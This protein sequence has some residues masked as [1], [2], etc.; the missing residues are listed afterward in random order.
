M[1]EPWLIV[2]I[3]IGG[4]ILIGI[5]INICFKFATRNYQPT[6]YFSEVRKE[7]PNVEDGHIH[8]S[9]KK[10]D[11]VYDK[12]FDWRYN[13]GLRKIWRFLVR[14]F[15]L[16]W[17]AGFVEPVMY[18]LIIKG[19]SNYRKHKKELKNGFITVCNHTY[20]LDSISIMHALY[21]KWNEFPIWKEGAESTSGS[22]FRV[23]GGIP[24]PR[25]SMR[26]IYYSMEAMRNVLR[27]KKW[28]HIFPEA[29]CWPFYVPIREFKD[30]TFKLAVEEGKPILPLGSSFRKRT[31]ISALFSKQPKTCIAIGEPLYPNPQLNKHDQIIDL[32]DR[33]QLAVMKLV[34][35]KSVEENEELK[36]RYSYYEYTLPTL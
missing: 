16:S 7:Y 20:D 2:L 15:V 17:F 18:G 12:D 5:L 25:D 28:L 26:G 1:L 27:E 6:P 13:K 4:I 19:K 30:G 14:V 21:P 22:A 31:G 32:R 3:V 23:A 9:K 36:K 29:A 8:A 11:F 35:I 33:V 34:G 10:Y 24:L